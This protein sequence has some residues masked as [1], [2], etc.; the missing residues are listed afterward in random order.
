LVQTF[1]RQYLQSVRGAS[2]HTVRAYR[3]ALR[4]FFAFLVDRRARR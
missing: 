3:D 4:L 1:F 2:D